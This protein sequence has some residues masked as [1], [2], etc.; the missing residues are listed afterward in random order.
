MQAP[1]ARNKLQFDVMIPRLQ[2]HGFPGIGRLGGQFGVPVEDVQAHR[3]AFFR[4]RYGPEAMLG[5]VVG[6]DAEFAMDA[7]DLLLPPLAS[8]NSRLERSTGWLS[9]GNPV[10]W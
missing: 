3:D 9:L 5:P 1:E 2:P 7:R 6:R 4:F 10:A 8:S